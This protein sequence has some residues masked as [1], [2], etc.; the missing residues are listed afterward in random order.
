VSGAERA[1]LDTV[2]LLEDEFSSIML[3]PGEGQLASFYRE[4][5]LEVWVRNISTPRRLYPGLHTIQ[6]WL[7]ANDLRKKAIKGVVCNTFA[8]ASRVGSA[9]RRA[10]I[11]LM[12]I[13]RDYVSDKRLYRQILN[14]ADSLV[15]VSRDVA[16]HTQPMVESKVIEVAY[17]SIDA[18]E[19]LAR[20]QKHRQ[21]GLRKIEWSANHPVVGWVGRITPYKQPEVFLRAIPLVLQHRPDARFVWVGGARDSEKEYQAG[22][23]VLIRDLGINDYLLYLGMRD[24]VAELMSEMSIFCLT[25]RREPLGR[26]ILEAQLAGCVV[27]APAVGGSVEIVSDGITGL[28]FQSQHVNAHQA[29]AEKIVYL[30]QNPGLASKMAAQGKEVAETHFSGPQSVQPMRQLLKTLVGV[31]REVLHDESA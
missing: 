31:R 13:L 17:D 3:V 23:Q 15:A 24:D 30:L 1:L 25:S 22:L 8:A 20:V 5:G 14:R 12:I 28:T 2:R 29:L 6:S 9:S 10:G 27:I 4:A 16:R 26:V 18:P 21:A 11:P 19:F 7:L